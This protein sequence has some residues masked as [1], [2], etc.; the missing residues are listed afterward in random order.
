VRDDFVFGTPAERLWDE[1]LVSVGVDP[2]AL[3]SWTQSEDGSE[4]AN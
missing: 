3:P 2:A 4:G 1:A